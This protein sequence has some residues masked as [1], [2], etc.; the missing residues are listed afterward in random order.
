MPHTSER[1]SRFFKFFKKGVALLLLLALLAL[2]SL[3]FYIN[4]K[5]N[6]I[7]EELL[8]SVNDELQGDFSVSGISLGSLFSY[9]NLEVSVRG[10][11]FHAPKKPEANGELILEVDIL[12]FKTDLSKILLKEIQIQDV[13][14]KGATLYVERDSSEQMVI[15]AGFRPYD[16]GS[17]ETDTTELK[18]SIDTIFIEESQVIILDRLSDL[19]LPFRLQK[20]TGTFELYKNVIKGITQIDLSP[21]NF[22]E[23]EAFIVNELPIK[24]HTNYLVDINQELVTVHGNDFYIADEHYKMNYRYDYTDQPNMEL[25]MSSLDSGVDLSALFVEQNDSLKNDQKIEL[26]GQGQ[27]RTDLRWNPDSDLPFLEALEASFMLEGKELNIYG[28]DLDEVIEKFK[29]SQEFNLADVSAVMFA[30]PAGLAVTKGTDFARLAFIKAGDS[31]RVNHF[32][33]DWKFNNGVLK[34]ED[35]AL[36]TNNNLIA[37]SGWYDLSKDSL[38]FKINILD[39]RGCELVGQRIYGDAKDPDYGKVNLLKTFF[40]PVTNF[41]RNIGVAQCD[42][43]YFGKVLHPKKEQKPN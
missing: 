11:Q 22:K 1:K 42:T 6:D 32:L 43:L 29:R 34:T 28:I 7:S 24:V 12:K 8:T 3:F 31:T 41:F 40:G 37:T 26:L 18:L 16:D 5:K 14:I 4:T 15:A 35:V 25:Q 13:Y 27:F 38:D 17:V 2:A 19:N 39:K 20:V 36:S 9:P 23:T 21:L 33:A 30:G 10:L